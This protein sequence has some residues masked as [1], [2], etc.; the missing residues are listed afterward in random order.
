MTATENIKIE[1]PPKGASIP[2]KEGIKKAILGI[3]KKALETEALD[4]IMIPVKVPETESYAW[5]LLK[6]T[7]LL[8]NADPLPPVM[9][10][11]GGKVLSDLTK[12]GKINK[13]IAAVLRP[14]E[15]RAAV[16]LF[17]LKQLH[18]E[19]ISLISI[20]CPGAIPLSEYLAEPE[21]SKKSFGNVLDKWDGD[22]AVRK[23]CQICYRFSLPTLTNAPASDLHIGLSGNTKDDILLIPVT[24][25]GEKILEKLDLKTDSSLQKWET[26]IKE[27]KKIKS[28][29]RKEFNRDFKANISGPEKFTAVFDGCIN[30]HNCQSVCPICYC[31][32]CYFDSATTKLSSEDYFRRAKE[33]GALRFPLDTILFHLG[34]MSHMALSC[35]SCGACEDACP[36]S[37]SVSQVFSLVGEQ[38]QQAFNYTPGINRGE[39]LPLQDYREDDFCEVETPSECEPTNSNE[40]KENV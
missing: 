32:Q 12:H 16:E 11:Q 7:T 20:D 17:K 3:F 31:Q 30:C 4:A 1:K 10:I 21:K 8:E 5:V 13:N 19:N 39:S 24:S 23:V 29:R 37:I 25:K 14:C 2:A 22:D 15:T 35:V 9:T 33:R 38:T 34:R 28:Q 26:K 18:F 36:M 27:I 6:D 40:V